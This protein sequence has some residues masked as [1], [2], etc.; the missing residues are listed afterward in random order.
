MA[1]LLEVDVIDAD[2]GTI[3]VTH[4][5][6]GETEREVRTNFAEHSAGCEYFRAA[7]DDDR[8]IETLEE[9]DDDDLPEVDDGDDD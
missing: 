8:I 6:W 1:Y 5:F 3:H 7:I 4:Q 9:I 2:D